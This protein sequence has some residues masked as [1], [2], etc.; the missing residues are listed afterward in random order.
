MEILFIY[1]EEHLN[2][3]SMRNVFET[4]LNFQELIIFFRKTKPKRIDFFKT[5]QTN[6]LKKKKLLH[7]FI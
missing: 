4:V 5:F 7:L 3:V 1:Y 2:K 6:H